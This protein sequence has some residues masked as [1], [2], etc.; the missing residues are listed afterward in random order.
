M[1]RYGGQLDNV[2]RNMNMGFKRYM[3]YGI[4]VLSINWVNNNAMDMDRHVMLVS[5][6]SQNCTLHC[7]FIVVLLLAGQANVDMS[8]I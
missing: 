3:V 4:C 2:N 1:S 6:G 8:I 7:T 5:L